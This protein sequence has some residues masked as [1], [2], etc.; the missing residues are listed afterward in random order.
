MNYVFKLD[1]IKR[2][3]EHWI[4]T[5]PNGYIGV[6]YARNPKELL[7]RPLDEDSA[8]TFLEWMREDIP[9]LKQLSDN[10]LSIVSEEIDF[11]SKTFYIQIGEILLPI[12]TVNADRV[13][14]L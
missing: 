1:D 11:E 12:Q 5:P 7:H 2:M 10:D 6:S 13:M 14:E 4:A 3:L 9:I 8:N